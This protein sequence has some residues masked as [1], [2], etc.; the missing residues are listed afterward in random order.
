M[1][2]ASGSRR[3][4]T[5]CEG[6]L[7]DTRGLITRYYE[8]LNAK[9]DGWKSLWAADAIFSDAPKT[10]HAQGSDAV[11]ESFGP[12]L[13]GVGSVE[14]VSSIVEGPDACFVIR[15]TYVNRRS[16]TLV[17]DVAEVWEVRGGAL[18]S[19]TL[20]FDLTAHRSFILG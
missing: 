6:G 1:V 2:R 16:E 10:L 19:L 18:S 17:Q 5:T 15:Y 20:Y 11:I 3:V 13:R 7:F 14:V 12:F 4:A 9:D 8:S